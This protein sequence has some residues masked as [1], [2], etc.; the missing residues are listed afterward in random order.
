MK[1]RCAG[2]AVVLISLVAFGVANADFIGVIDPGTTVTRVDSVTTTTPDMTF[3][4]DG[5][6][7]T[8]MDTWTFA[9]V[10]YPEFVTVHGI[11]QGFPVHRPYRHPATDTWLPIGMGVVTSHVWWHGDLGVEESKSVA[12]PLQRL[13]VSPSVVTGQMTVRL[14]HVDVSRPVVEIHDAVGNVI[15]SLNCTAG[16][17]GTATATWN[18]EDS[19]GRIVPEG[20]Y[21]CRYAASGTAAVRKVLVAH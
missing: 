6:G 19:Y 8:P 13:A 12:E 15:R 20:V 21:F 9:G 4:T 10:S 17:N 3:I 2:L 7:T 18:R 1:K 5:W 14:Q 16:A 11:V